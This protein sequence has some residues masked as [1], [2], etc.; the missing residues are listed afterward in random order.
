TRRLRL[1]VEPRVGLVCGG[2]VLDDDVSLAFGVDACSLLRQTDA[3]SAQAGPE[4]SGQPTSD[5]GSEDHGG[6]A[7]GFRWEHYLPS[8]WCRRY[9]KKIPGNV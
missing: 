5:P 8:T 3:A 4:A 1:E 7:D 6:R 9:R 2:P